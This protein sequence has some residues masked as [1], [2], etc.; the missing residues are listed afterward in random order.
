MSAFGL[1]EEV[2]LLRAR[3]MGKKRVLFTFIVLLFMVGTA[4]ICLVALRDKSVQTFS[5]ETR[6]YLQLVIDPGHGGL[7]GGASTADGTTESVINLSVALR[8]RE[9]ALL[10][11]ENPI[12][13]R[14]SET[15]EYPDTVSTIREKKVWD[16]KRRASLINT[17]ERAVLISVHQNYYPDARP[18]GPVVLYGSAKGSSTLAEKVQSAFDS[19]LCPENRRVSAPV[20]PKIYLMKQISCPAIL[21]ECGFLSNPTEAEQLKNAE[22]QKKLAL[23]LVMSYLQYAA[24]GSGG[25]R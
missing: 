2:K 24:D 1:R 23:I 18:S 17:T 9:L 4:I 8:M 5:A 20:S 13:T 14:S 7:D 6:E 15:L 10:F 25:I 3:F 22:Y 19:S 12:M 16:Q 11:G 21:V